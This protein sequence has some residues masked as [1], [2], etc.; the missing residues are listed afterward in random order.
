MAISNNKISNLINSQVPFFVRNDHQNFVT[1]LEKYYEYLEQND[2]V[3]NRIKKSQTYRDI[4]LTETEFA[5]K[6]YDTFMKYVP[7]NILADKTL[8]IKHIKDF[9]RAKG[10]EK[11]TR[12]LIRILHNEE[13][14]FYY[15]KADILRVSDGKWFVQK[16]LKIQD[17]QIDN[18]QAPLIS[19]LEKYIGIL[20]K[21]ATSNATALVERTDRYYER[22]TLIDELFLTNIVGSFK[23]GESIS[24]T[25]N[26]EETQQN[27]KSNVYSGIVNSITLQNG[28]FGYAVGYSIPIESNS[29]V[30]AAAIISSVS[31]GSIASIGVLS[32]GAGY[33]A[34]DQILF[35]GGGTGSGATAN[36]FTVFNDSSI[37]PN[38]YNIISTIINLEANTAIG[39]SIYSNLISAITDPA[40]NWISNSM[41]FWTYANTGPAKTI[42]VLNEGQNYS[43]EPSLSIIANSVIQ[44]LGILGH[45]EIIDGGQNYKIGDTIE[46]TNV[47]GGYGVGAAANVTN[48]DMGNSNTI[49]QVNFVP[50]QGQ[51]VGGSGY[52][53]TLLPTANVISATGTGANIAVT[54]ILGSGG[55][56]KAA[57]SSIGTI[58]TI[59][60]INGG[61]GYTSPPTINL[62]QSG[63]GTAIANA[64]IV[65]GIYTYPGRYLNDDGHISSYNFL[66]DRDYY[67]IFSY[68]IKSTKPINSYKNALTDLTHPAGMKLFG[69]VDLYNENENYIRPDDADDSIK[70]IL[71]SK[72]YTKNGNTINISYIS[73]G[74]LV[75]SNVYIEY[76]SGGIDSNVFNG[77]YMISNTAT[78]YFR[79]TQNVANTLNTSGNLIV[80]AITT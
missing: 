21:G 69:E 41:S 43:E 16:S 66:E 79:V 70:I 58:K 1:F 59:T 7:K 25:V 33:R 5:E 44:Q 11:A 67:Q 51:F 75:N 4:D 6:L 18:Q 2:K 28:G 72:T 35:S 45:M 53:Q 49:T 56:L 17:T 42:Y 34:N 9:Y 40:N 73:H 27:I 48:V 62:K 39:N 29:G 32:G 20:V 37:H 77:I 74:Y 47:T 30:G 64:T 68:V 26:L 61:S 36:V 12:F 63:D 78:N 31:T 38:S 19:D 10:T 8:I 80:G 3:V 14:E 22:G 55:T 71:N 52:T 60:L 65:T 50:V 13:I 46:F 57:N 15:P 76:T 54:A 24:G 23:D